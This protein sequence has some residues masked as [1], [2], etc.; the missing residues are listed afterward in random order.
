[1]SPR[2]LRDALADLAREAGM[3]VRVTS[4][5][6]EVE[7]G[8]PI[9]SGVCR[10]RGVWWVVLAGD[11]PVESHVEMLAGALRDHAAGWL[12]SRYLPPAVRDALERAQG[13]GPS[14]D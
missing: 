5:A 6:R 3:D 14:R 11:D 1:V 13:A 9:Q 8:I 4:G 10:V 7:P 2:E 12:E